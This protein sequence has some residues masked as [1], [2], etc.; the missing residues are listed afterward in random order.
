MSAS[1]D[2]I[3]SF[4]PGAE[5]RRKEKE[6]RRLAERGAVS[7]PRQGRARRMS[8][9]CEAVASSSDSSDS[10]Y[11]SESDTG[12]DT[13]DIVVATN[14][15]S[16]NSLQGSAGR[17]RPGS[18]IAADSHNKKKR[19]REGNRSQSRKKPH[20]VTTV[21]AAH[22]T[23]DSV[24]KDYNVPKAVLNIVMPV[25]TFR[26]QRMR[27]CVL[28]PEHNSSSKDHILYH[29]TQF[30]RHLKRK[31]RSFVLKLMERDD[32]ARAVAYAK[33]QVKRECTSTTRQ[34]LITDSFNLFR[35]KK[36]LSKALQAVHLLECGQ[37]FASLDKKSRQEAF[38]SVDVDAD[39]LLSSDSMRKS[40]LPAMEQAVRQR[41][42]SIFEQLERPT[43]AATA[44]CWSDNKGAPYLGIT[45]HYIDE[46][47]E[48][49]HFLLNLAF[50]P[51]SHT[52]QYLRDMITASIDDA[53]PYD[54]TVVLGMTVDGASNAIGS[55]AL[56]AG[57]VSAQL[58][59]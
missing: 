3:T 15:R 31:H 4:D 51:E 6:G 27:K 30:G 17:Q 50:A 5:R 28:P 55:A 42:R 24:L 46:R 29:G 25:T 1:D 45:G 9:Y 56:Y 44:D 22:S 39:C 43:L 8:D 12:S 54:R 41:I 14:I 36:L 40:M 21:D 47:L 33:K 53:A 37:S 23:I 34:L 2:N 59:V 32:A 19:K 52:S 26:S 49:H 57:A 35:E 10:D 18:A 7:G 20:E 11:S 48:P 13:T 58:P 38:T 16:D